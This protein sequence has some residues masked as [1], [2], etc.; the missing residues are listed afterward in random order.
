MNTQERILFLA[1]YLEQGLN[2]GAAKPLDDEL[3]GHPD[4]A[5]FLQH[6]G[7]TLSFYKRHQ[8]NSQ[9]VGWMADYLDQQLPDSVRELVQDGH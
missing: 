9:M 6:Y 8:L 7:R 4:A 3:I 2:R 5:R 1:N